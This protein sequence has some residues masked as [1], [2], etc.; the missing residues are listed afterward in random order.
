MPLSLEQVPAQKQE[1][2]LNAQLL[3][4]L[5]ILH[6]PQ[7]R[8]EA[9]VEQQAKINPFLRIEKH[10]TLQ[11]YPVSSLS[12]STASAPAA[13]SPS[14]AEAGQSDGTHLLPSQSSSRQ[15]L[16]DQIAEM[17]YA[18][19]AERAML[20]ILL[21]HIDPSDGYLRTPLEEISKEYK[22]LDEEDLEDALILLQDEIEPAGVGARNLQECL[23]LQARRIVDEE[24]RLLSMIQDHLGLA[25]AG[26]V[27]A[28]CHAMDIDQAT[29]KRLLD[30][31]NRLDASPGRNLAPPEPTVSPDF[32]ITV[33]EDENLEIHSLRSG[34]FIVSIASDAEHIV[35]SAKDKKE[36]RD[37]RSK[38]STAQALK[39]AI[40]R[41]IE[42]ENAVVQA[43][44]DVQRSFFVDGFRGLRP[45]TQRE[46]AE[47]IGMHE[48]TI[49]RV[50]AG[51]YVLTP[52]GQTHELREFFSR[53]IPTESGEAASSVA[54]K[55]MIRKMIADEKP[56][57]VLSDNKIAQQLLDDHGIQIARRTVAKYRKL[58]R[59]P[60]SSQ[61]RRSH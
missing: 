20:H 15:L 18:D 10:G 61:R 55:I 43:I 49:S 57:G 2:R 26:N 4:S 27:E 32:E 24:P 8:L 7:P 17:S 42:T 29:A 14:S 21:N 30:R 3:Q 54:V 51:R 35:D 9:F 13:S 60:T 59:I 36:R 16:L 12:S 25:K 19:D 40:D 53:A 31:Y 50:V 47:A 5:R 34:S 23:E 56:S 58:L 52:E 22:D 45:L 11:E 38:F 37:L 46:V 28:L 6:L 44:V 41:R 48:S 33:D 39:S 1:L